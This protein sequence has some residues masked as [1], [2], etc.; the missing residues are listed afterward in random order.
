MLRVSQ[1]GAIIFPP[2][3]AFYHKPKTI[4]EMINHTTGKILDLFEIEH[5][6]FRRWEGRRT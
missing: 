4:D 3:P 1:M 5:T 6:L 2:V